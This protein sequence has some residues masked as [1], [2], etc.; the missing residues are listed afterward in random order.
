MTF[1]LALQD[2]QVPKSGQESADLKGSKQGAGDADVDNADVPKA[3]PQKTTKPKAVKEVK[4]KKE[5]G[6]PRGKNAF[7]FFV[8][9]KR[10]AVKGAESPLILVSQSAFDIFPRQS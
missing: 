10:E 6:P 4:N 2:L 8:V 3:A 9:A 5:K 7:M 1:R